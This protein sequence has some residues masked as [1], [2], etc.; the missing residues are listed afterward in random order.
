MIEMLFFIRFRG[1]LR[2][3]KPELIESLEEIV[4]TAASAAGGSVETRYKILG[5]SFDEDRIGFWLDIVILLE[6][7]QKALERAAPELYD[8][9]LVLGR[10]IPETSVR[11]LCLSLT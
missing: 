3:T 10:D 8:Y 7:I 5:A 2:R 9:A 1:Q 11:K 4:T 6:R